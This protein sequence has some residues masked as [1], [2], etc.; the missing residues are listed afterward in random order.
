MKGYNSENIGHLNHRR[1]TLIERKND[2]I[3]DVRN[4]KPVAK[5]KR[6]RLGK[7]IDKKINEIDLL[8]N[9]IHKEIRLRKKDNTWENQVDSML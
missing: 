5:R 3:S 4:T 9:K 7:L 2:L 6:D 1:D 8:C